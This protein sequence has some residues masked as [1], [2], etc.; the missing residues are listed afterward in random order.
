[1]R[2]N[3]DFLPTNSQVASI[4]DHELVNLLSRCQA[5]LS[6]GYAIPK[7][8]LPRVNCLLA[9]YEV[10]ISDRRQFSAPQMT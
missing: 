1:M 8:E 3:R 7:G 6:G 5:R 10:E 9:E 4:M 2:P